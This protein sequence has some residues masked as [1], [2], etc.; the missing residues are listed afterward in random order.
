[1][2]QNAVV[3]TFG[4]SLLFHDGNPPFAPSGDSGEQAQIPFRFG[5]SGSAIGRTEQPTQFS[6]GFPQNPL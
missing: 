2:V 1:V 4:G 3:Q 6:E 5:I